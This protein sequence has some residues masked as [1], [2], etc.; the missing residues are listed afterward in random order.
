MIFNLLGW[1]FILTGY[2]MKIDFAIE[3]SCCDES[4]WCNK[5][6]SFW[7]VVLA[8]ETAGRSWPFNTC[9][10]A[11]SDMQKTI[12]APYVSNESTQSEGRST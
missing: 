10:V 8:E 5:V 1:S 11:S 3:E 7:E 12:L 6:K 2:V 9:P 4:C